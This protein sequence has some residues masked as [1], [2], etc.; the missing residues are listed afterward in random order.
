LAKIGL[1]ES[2]ADAQRK[3][4]ANAVELNGEKVTDQF[5][6]PA[7]GEHVFKVGRNWRKALVL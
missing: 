7:P 1:A 4:K 5:L 3:L 6:I 2:V